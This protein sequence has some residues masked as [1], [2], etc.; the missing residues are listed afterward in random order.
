MIL[1]AR[2][3]NRRL[4][5]LEADPRQDRGQPLHSAGVIPSSTRRLFR[6]RIF[7]RARRFSC[8]MR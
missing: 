5:P 3:A 6:C 4:W 8:E 2:T 1:D 7:T